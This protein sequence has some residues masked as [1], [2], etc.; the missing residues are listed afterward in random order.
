MKIETRDFGEVE[1]DESKIYTIPN[2]I[3]GFEDTKRYTLLSPLGEDT[4]PM[5]LQAVDSKTP[6]FVV[7]DPMLIYSDYSFAI[8]DEEQELL[9]ITADSPYRCLAVAIVP[10]DYRKTTINL[11]CPIVV[12]TN[13]N[14]AMQIMLD[15]YDFKCPVYSE[16][17]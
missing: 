5:W 12:N 13:D 9:K 2:G 15:E 17:A 3:I 7:Y 4:F 14:I 10:D 8:S 11:R 6:C 16:E 1:I